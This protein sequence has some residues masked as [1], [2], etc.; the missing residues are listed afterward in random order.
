MKE[1]S[2]KEL[3][4]LNKD[5]YILVDTRNEGSLKY[6]MIPGAVSITHELFETD[7]EG[8]CKR[9]DKSKQI[10]LYCTRGVI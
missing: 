9:L 5:E 6:G 4:E 10:I 3:M 1:I 7:L 2:F 8:V